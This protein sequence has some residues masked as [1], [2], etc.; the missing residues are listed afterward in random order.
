[1]ILAIDTTGTT[2]S[3]AI[4]QADKVIHEHTLSN[5]FTHSVNLLPMIDQIFKKTG[6]TID[7]IE[8][9]AVSVGPG[10]FTGVRIGVSTAK[11]LAHV[12]C[13]PVIP[14]STLDALAYNVK[15]ALSQ[16]II[17]IMDARRGQVYTAIYHDGVKG[18]DLTLAMPSLIEKAKAYGKSC[19]FLGDGV[20]VHQEA[21]EKA[22]FL[23]ADEIDCLQKSSSV[24]L[25]AENFVATTYD[26][27]VPMYLRKPQAVRELNTV[28]VIDYQAHL[29][30]QVYDL[31]N[32]SIPNFWSKSTLEM[33][34][35]A[36]WSIYLMATKEEDEKNK[37]IGALGAHHTVDQLEIMNFA[38][39]INYRGEGVGLHLFRALD[40]FCTEKKISHLYLEVRESNM[41]ARNFYEKHGF[42]VIRKREGYYQ[43]PK[44]DAWV[45][46]RNIGD[47]LC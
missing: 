9:I 21:I 30:D 2:C 33:D 27:L 44:E 19:L 38:V 8:K 39:D 4:L 18:D 7:Q 17:P 41:I 6:I 35:Q 14:V 29:L 36:K 5:G 3:V 40:T 1:M 25:I 13:I 15:G 23:I 28:R 34:T 12:H 31:F 46:T 10:S 26:K 20:F 24:G 47:R 22:G 16:L 42:I 11:A 43:N 37:V 45:M 32:R